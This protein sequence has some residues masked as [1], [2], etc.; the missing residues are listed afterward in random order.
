M[1]Q[2]EVRSEYAKRMGQALAQT[3]DRNLLSLLVKAARDT[4]AGGLGVGAV[5][6]ANAASVNI[7]ANPTVQQIVDAM[8]TAARVFDDRFIP[9]SDRYVL[10]S[11]ATYWSLVT[12]DKLINKD[13]NGG[14]GNYSDGKVYKVAGMT[15]VKT[16]NLSVDHTAAVGTF[17]D[18][19]NKYAVN[20]SDTAFVAMTPEA[21]GTV[22]LMDLTSEME[23]QM[24]RQGTLMISKMAVG[25]GVL[26]P[27][28][29]YEGRRA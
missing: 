5:G 8:Y 28:A 21:L 3:Y 19:A 23:Y 17:P 16:P 14:N 2:Y 22:K 24:W 18:Y 10:V 20:A 4:G 26:R 7:G 6:Q 11:P 13:F 15:L 27:E 9:E 12:N 1:S 25:H 29:I